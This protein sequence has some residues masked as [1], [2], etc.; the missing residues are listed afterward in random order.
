MIAPDK[1][2]HY[3]YGYYA[4]KYGAI[5]GF[6]VIIAAAALKELADLC[7][8]GTPELADFKISVEGAVDG[9]LWRKRKY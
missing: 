2:R 4:A 5:I 8:L 9:L 6:V 1:I 7:G 3:R